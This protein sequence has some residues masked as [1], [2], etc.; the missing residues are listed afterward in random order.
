MPVRLKPTT[1]RSQVKHSTTEPPHSPFCLQIAALSFDPEEDEEDE[2][3]ECDIEIKK[4]PDD[5]IVIKKKRL[6]K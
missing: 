5:D 6:G 2:G 3:E 4:E 1:P